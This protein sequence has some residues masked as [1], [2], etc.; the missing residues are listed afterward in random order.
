MCTAPRAPGLA[1]LLLIVA[2][3]IGTGAALFRWRAKDVREGILAELSSVPDDPH[4]RVAVWLRYGEPQI[5][6]GLAHLRFSSAVP[7]LVCYVRER[8]G[9]APEVYGVDLSG[10]RPATVRQDGL[11]VVV[12]VPPP[13][14]VW[15]GGLRGP[16]AD[17]IV[18]VG[19]DDPLPDAERIAR[20][21]IEW[22]FE[23]LAAALPRDI[24]GAS[25]AIEFAPIDE[26]SSGARDEG[27]PGGGADA[28]GGPGGG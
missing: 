24:P 16:N 21:R 11:R 5:Q 22:L 26:R 4:E 23:G 13:R 1:V 12:R 20:E 7:A 8:P 19:P 9:Q 14:M 28:A 18:R 10:P 3:G 6:S 2:V 27:L 17:R 25:L 15:R